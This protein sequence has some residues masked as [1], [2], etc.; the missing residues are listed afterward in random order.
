MKKLI[1]KVLTQEKSIYLCSHGDLIPSA[2]EELAGR[3]VALE[4][5]GFAILEEEKGSWILV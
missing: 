1:K 3:P 4:K 2:I 5:C